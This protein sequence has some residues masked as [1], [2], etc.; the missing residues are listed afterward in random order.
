MRTITRNIV[1]AMIWSKDKKLFLGKKHADGGG[2]YVDC[3]HIPGGGI[4]PGEEY[5]QAL[6][7]EILEE[8][9]LIIDSSPTVLIDDI[10]RGEA[11]KTLSQTGEK[12]LCKMNFYVYK[13]NVELPAEEIKI[14]V[15]DDLAEYQWVGLDSLARINLTPPSVD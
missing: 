6:R 10:G 13:V 15:G 8:T 12:V 4:E 7:R 5:L 14:S 11:Q 2:V 9:G 1:C 3:W